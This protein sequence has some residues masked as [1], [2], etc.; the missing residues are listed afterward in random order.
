M[1]QLLD[2]VED[3]PELPPLVAAGAE[4][5]LPAAGAG[6]AGASLLGAAFAAPL[7]LPAAPPPSL[8]AGAGGFAEEYRSL[9]Q[10]APLN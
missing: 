3:D 10:P 6:D 9:Y 8:L 4:A 1:G 2:V 5:E 7:L